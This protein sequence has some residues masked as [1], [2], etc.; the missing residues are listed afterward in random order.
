MVFFCPFLLAEGKLVLLAPNQLL[1]L[2]HS[3]ISNL[4]VPL[5]TTQVVIAPQAST[6]QATAPPVMTTST[7]S[8]DSQGRVAS[9]VNTIGNS[10]GVPVAATKTSVNTDGSLSTC[11]NADNKTTQMT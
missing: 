1:S 4:S 3:M 10:V 9:A 8:K 6:S 7:S 11:S 5:A 2:P